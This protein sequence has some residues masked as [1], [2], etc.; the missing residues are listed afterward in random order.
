LLVALTK[1][2]SKRALLDEFDIVLERHLGEGGEA[3]VDDVLVPYAAAY[4]KLTSGSQ[5]LP[6]DLQLQVDLLNQHQSEDWKPVAMWIL[7]NVADSAT[8]LDLITKL[9]RLFGVL[10]IAHQGSETRSARLAGV[11][12]ALEECTEKAGMVA[13]NHSLAVGDEL[14]QNAL[15]RMKAPLPRGGVVRRVLLTRAHVAASG[16]ATGLP[17]E[18][19]VGWA[20][21]HAGERE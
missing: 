17:L 1:N 13:V 11:L 15:Y 14:R 2:P 9:E 10:V 16:G 12:R 19:E 5:L 21:P 4:L 20:H 7:V 3:F 8:V 6:R 18:A